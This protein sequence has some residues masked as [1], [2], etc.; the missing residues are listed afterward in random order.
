MTVGRW[1]LSR[2]LGVVIVQLLVLATIVLLYLIVVS[3]GRILD[4]L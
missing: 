1:R 4:F 2:Q 3:R